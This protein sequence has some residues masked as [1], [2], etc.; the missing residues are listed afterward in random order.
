MIL[1]KACPR[2]GGDVDTTYHDD[3]YCVQCAY[4]PAVVFPG[5]RIVEVRRQHG[6]GPLDEQAAGRQPGDGEV[7]NNTG[8]KPICPKCGS[9][10]LVRLDKLRPGDHTCYR[11]RSCGHIFSPDM[12]RRRARRGTTVS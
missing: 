8:E 2:C 7:A 3:I 11:C 6:A 1:F 10:Q 5:P 12:E 9:Q 4:R